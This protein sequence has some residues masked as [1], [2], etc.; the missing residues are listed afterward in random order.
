MGV[1][2]SSLARTEIVAVLSRQRDELGILVHG[3]KTKLEALADIQ[4]LTAGQFFLIK[5]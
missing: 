5:C 1:A 3:P 4:L 2:I